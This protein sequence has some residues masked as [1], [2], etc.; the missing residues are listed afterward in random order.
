MKYAFFVGE[1]VVF[2][3]KEKTEKIRMNEP[4]ALP[5]KVVYVV[6]AAVLLVV[7]IIGLVMPI[8][9]GV[10]FLLAALLV[11]GKVSRRVHVWSHRHPALR[12]V[13]LRMAGLGR[14][15][16]VDRMK[17]VG[18]MTLEMM[19]KGAGSAMLAGKS[20]ISRFRV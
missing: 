5:I 20:L 18:W 14:V 3:M 15:G 4:M 16:V 9:P 17:L 19:V 12:S 2:D 7:G 6:L 13:R 10:V 1:I 11:L 8:L